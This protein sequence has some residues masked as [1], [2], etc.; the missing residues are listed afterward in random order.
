MRDA[1]ASIAPEGAQEKPSKPIRSSRKTAEL[2]GISPRQV[3]RARTIVDHGDDALLW[4]KLTTDPWP[5][6]WVVSPMGV[7]KPGHG[8]SSIV[9]TLK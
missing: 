2:L 7:F 3:E 6:R 9:M 4:S 1:K 5:C 8:R